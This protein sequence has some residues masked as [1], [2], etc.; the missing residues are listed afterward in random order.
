MARRRGILRCPIPIQPGGRGRLPLIHLLGIGA[1]AIV[2]VAVLTVAHRSV[3]SRVAF[4]RPLATIRIL[5][6]PVGWVGAAHAWWVFLRE[7]VVGGGGQEARVGGTRKLPL[8]RALWAGMSLVLIIGIGL[9][10]GPWLEY[11]LK[12]QD[13][14]MAPFVRNQWVQLMWALSIGCQGVIYG[15]TI[16]VVMLLLESILRLDWGNGRLLIHGAIVAN[17]LGG[18][19]FWLAMMTLIVLRG[20]LG[21]E[22]STFSNWLGFLEPFTLQLVFILLINLGMILVLRWRW[23]R[24]EPEFGRREVSAAV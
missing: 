19:S 8:R 10:A 14:E 17:F 1:L 7:G 9:F 21:F 2:G 11:L 23:K 22:M 3:F 18:L 5:T 12:Y 20:R 13:T 15:I 4:N 24:G 6:D 16:P